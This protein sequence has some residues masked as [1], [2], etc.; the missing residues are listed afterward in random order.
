MKKI[1]K[2]Y[3]WLFL[4]GLVFTS[5]KKFLTQTS[6][7]ELIP[8]SVADLT[9]LM[10][11]EAYPYIAVMDSYIDLLTDDI[12]CTGIP[13]NGSLTTDVYRGFLNY[14]API[15]TFDA[16]MF[17]ST[18]SV[19]LVNL[20]GVDSWKIYYGKIKGCNVVLDYISK[21]SGT[22]KEKSALKGQVLFLRGF[23][24][25]KLV[26]LY[27]QP[28]NGT[29]ID[30]ATAAGVPLILTSQ[31]TDENKPR[32][33]LGEVYSQIEKD[34]L[35]AADLLKNNFVPG[36]TFRAGHLAAY[37]LLSRLYLYM[38]RDQ[39]MDN[40]ILY[41]GNVLAEKPA[42]T[43]LTTYFTSATAFNAAGI[44]DLTYSQEVI[45][46]YSS[47]PKGLAYFY[48]QSLQ[49]GASQPPFSVSQELVNLYDQGTGSG[50]GNLGD[51]RYAAYFVKTSGSPAWP[52]RSYKVGLNVIYGDKGLR[53]AELYLNRA[54]A[55]IR[56]YKKSGAAADLS[57]ALSDL[58]TL[59]ISRYDTRNTAYVPVTI[60]NP[61]A[62]LSFCRD[63]RR[64]ELCLEDG[65]R[66]ADLKRW[67]LSV[68]HHFI[69][70]NGVASDYTLAG[71]SPLYAL[72]IPYTAIN[73]NY[74]L[75]QNPR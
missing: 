40:V 62:L 66:W 41:A 68:T 48:P 33:T 75:Q 3:S 5:C 13:V 44:Y 63:E 73:R 57:L 39:D 53:V 72:P 12:Q 38:G 14:G 19:N 56:R 54:E 25:L 17:D 49:S 36:N 70:V 27:C 67:G 26:T 45:W 55:L 52:Y 11:G 50:T 20:S 1:L 37:A 22:D 43:F 10:N 46:Q 29:G 18:Q 64:R 65:H 35:E 51:L 47:N 74:N 8:S 30:P 21:V 4:A 59:R 28:Y 60:T 15:F 61:D 32:N 23:Y 6:Q 58:N 31:V 7:D 9:Q 42:L 34:L 2:Q 24:Y 16:T 69:D 71:N